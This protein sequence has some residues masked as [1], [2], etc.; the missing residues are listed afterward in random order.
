MNGIKT[1]IHFLVYRAFQFNS[2][3]STNTYRVS[4]AL[5]WILRNENKV[6]Y[7][8]Y[9]Q[10]GKCKCINT[11]QCDKCHMLTVFLS[12]Q[13]HWRILAKIKSFLD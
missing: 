13:F 4:L 3:H 7:S 12:D 11:L 5:G 2:I 10:G 8:P 1:N 9:S 6:R